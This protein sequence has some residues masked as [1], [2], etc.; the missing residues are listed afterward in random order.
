MYMRSRQSRN[1]MEVSNDTSKLVRGCIVPGYAFRERNL[2]ILLISDFDEIGASYW[3]AQAHD[4]WVLSFD[5]M[6]S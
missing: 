2:T 1:A 4:V 3:R 5:G 6:K